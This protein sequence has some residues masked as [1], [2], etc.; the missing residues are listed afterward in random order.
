MKKNKVLYKTILIIIV[1]ITIISNFGTSYAAAPTDARPEQSILDG[2]GGGAGGSEDNKDNK[3][4]KGSGSTGLPSLDSFTP[5]ITLGGASTIVGGILGVLM[6]VGT[7]L[8]VVSL[9]LIGFLTILGSASEKADYQQKLV[10]VIFAGIFM[11]ASSSIA[12]LIISV[13]ITF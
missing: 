6:I 8:I 7:V 4:N 1:I 12:K 9:A 2:T 10:G 11:V 5:S 13:A 3:D